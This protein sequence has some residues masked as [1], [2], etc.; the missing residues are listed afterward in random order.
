MAIT[1]SSRRLD[2]V[3][4]GEFWQEKPLGEMSADEWESLCDGCA[5]CCLQKLED[6]DTG[7]VHYTSVVCKHLDENNCRCTDYASRSVIV[8]NCVQLTPDRVSEFAWLPS[9]CAYRLLA[10]NNTL[11]AH[12]HTTVYTETRGKNPATAHANPH[13]ATRP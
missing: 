5:R 4:M 6:I 12:P 11:P 8:P 13:D 1:Y 9:T 3:F 7:E 2:Q 10:E